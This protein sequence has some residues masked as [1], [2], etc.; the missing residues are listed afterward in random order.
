MK[1]PNVL[2]V[3]SDQHRWSALNCYGNDDV[4]SPSFDK[5]AAEG[6]RYSHCVSSS[7]V[8]CPFRA[9]LQTGLYPNQHGVRL[10][11]SPWLGQQFR[12]LPD[13][14]NEAGYETCYIGK[15]HW[16]RSLTGTS[17][18]GFVPPSARLRWKHWFGMP[19]HSQ[20]DSKTFDDDGNVAQ[21]YDEQYQPTV[22]ADLALEQI[23]KFGDSPWLIQ[24]NWGPPHE[25]GGKVRIK[26]EELI[27]I[28]HR[29][30]EEYGFGLSRELIDDYPRTKLYNIIPQHLVSTHRIMPDECLERY[31][32]KSLRVEPNVPEEFRKMVGYHLKEYYGLVTSLDDELAKIMKFLKK[33][34]HDKDT[35]V[36]YT[37]DHGDKIAAHCSPTKFRTKST[38]HQN[39]TRVPLIV[40]GPH[41]GVAQGKINDTP[42]NSVDLL[43]TLLEIIGHRVDPHLPGESFVDT[44]IGDCTSRKR[45]V[46]LSLDSWRG[47]YDGQ[48]LYTIDSTDDSWKPVS[49]IDTVADPYDLQNLIDDPAYSATQKRLQSVLERELF[50]ASD[51]E[52]L[53]KTGMLNR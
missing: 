1:K 5:L 47:I 7:P 21:D 33:T 25:V 11:Q 44:F 24:L 10:N 23:E 52:F 8:C 41:V 32:Y 42:I 43:P 12:S 9:T 30:N 29:V 37:S 3:L 17:A 22:Q 18:N 4:I 20:Y 6:V 16:G 51:Y 2:F 31:N 19:G 46:L 45:E 27:A 53:Q 36:V 38:W 26:G 14:F 28:A 35:I 39:A 50:R 40:W 34:G 49:L 13:Y 48:Y 15:V